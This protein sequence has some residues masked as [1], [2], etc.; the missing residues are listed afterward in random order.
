MS[1][2]LPHAP[3]AVAK[4]PAAMTGLDKLSAV[5]G[6]TG[7][8]H[9][10]SG[11]PN[12]LG[13][14]F[15]PQRTPFAK[16]ITTRDGETI[17]TVSPAG[18]LRIYLNAIS[19]RGAVLETEWHSLGALLRLKPDRLPILTVQ[20]LLRQRASEGKLFSREERLPQLA[21][22]DAW[23]ER[24]FQTE[25]GPYSGETIS[26]WAWIISAESA[27]LALE[28]FLAGHTEKPFF[29]LT[30]LLDENRPLKNPRL[31]D[32]LLQ[33]IHRHYVDAMPV[34]SQADDSH[35]FVRVAQLDLVR[36]LKRLVHH[37]LAS[38]PALLPSVAKFVS[39]IIEAQATRTGGGPGRWHAARCSLFNKALWYFSYPASFNTMENMAFNWE[40]QKELLKLSSRMHPTLFIGK[41]GYQAIRRVMVALKKTS[42]EREVVK[43]AGKT[44]PPYRRA[45]DGRD[46]GLRPEDSLSRSARA[47]S[48]M[49]EAGYPTDDVDR[50]LDVL[51]GSNLGQTPT[52]Q[53]RTLADR[54]WVGKN[55]VLNVFAE[56]CS[57]IEATRNTREAWEAFSKPPRAGLQ[58]NA[59]VYAKV[60]EKLF[61]REASG[62]QS[63]PLPGDARR[64]FP[65][66]DGNLSAFEI[67][68]ITPPTSKDL[69][70]MMLSSGVRPVG[71]CLDV[72]VQNAR[73]K[74]EAIKYLLDSTSENSQLASALQSPDFM[75]H[76]N[77]EVIG[78]MARP[79]LRAW[80][81]MLCATHH[82]SRRD[83]IEEAIKL[84]RAFEL[85][86]P[87]NR[88]DKTTWRSILDA[89]AGQKVAYG[90]QMAAL[91]PLKTLQTFL[92][93]WEKARLTAGFNPILFEQLCRVIS[94][95]LRLSVFSETKDE[96]RR[97]P[98]PFT[99]LPLRSYL[100]RAYEL[101][102]HCFV[103]DLET[104]VYS[105]QDKKTT[106][107]HKITGR[108]VFR[109]MQAL[110]TMGDVGGAVRLMDW[111]LDAWG[112]DDV[113]QEAKDSHEPE[114][115]EIIASISCF[116]G[117][118]RRMVDAE[119]RQRLANRLEK[120]KRE[121]GCTWYWSPATEDYE[122]YVNLDAVL[123]ERYK[124]PANIRVKK[125]QW[126]RRG[127]QE[128]QVDE[129]QRGSLGR[130]IR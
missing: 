101:L 88:V 13:Y 98:S 81:A 112:R 103:V 72:L 122:R 44:W 96:L 90:H 104:S 124:F 28:R 86:S 110:S 114:Y 22:D 65:A 53:T 3:D 41:H 95:T 94:K 5:L 11:I 89:L 121:R 10:S 76:E 63:D 107:V 79:L 57:R 130:S 24:L 99:P 119:T 15:A 62:H 40:A 127:G 117:M 52:I 46:E 42:S 2:R 18:A 87:G 102:E 48:L 125:L 1:L 27:D 97:H 92:A 8:P 128:T 105:A 4:G 23:S 37:S 111:L 66:Y 67:A 82:W 26:E 77:A 36:L 68:R 60:F 91:N 51:G 19:K 14:E 34:P 50:A 78:K 7:K 120:L 109:Y 73:T 9:P 106:L 47:G 75:R 21:S 55:A 74:T 45:W 33:Y 69:Y 115:H 49:V 84:G 93:V 12:A 80:V 29:L 123:E 35:E 39:H 16:L 43:R 17:E 83:H 54:T 70:E 30:I 129:G 25:D 85:G 108:Q 71:R 113:L 6:T 126:R 32:E 64:V 31:F 118:A 56:W 100:H 59:N 61:A 58:P 116:D 20:A 38:F